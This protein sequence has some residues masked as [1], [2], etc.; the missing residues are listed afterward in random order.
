MNRKTG[1]SL[2]GIAKLLNGQVIG[3]ADIIISDLAKIE[4]ANKNSITFIANPKYKQFLASTK[5]GAVL[6]NKDLDTA[7]YSGKNFVVVEDPY[8]SFVKLFSLFYPQG[9]MLPQEISES[10]Y[11]HPSAKV[12]EGVHIAPHVYIGEDCVV[13]NNVYL[14]PGVVLLKNVTVGDDTILYPNVSVRENC[15]IGKRV[16]IHNGGVIGSDGFG[17]A[18]QGGEYHKIPQLGI[19][20]IEDD[21]ELG[22]NITID[23]ATLGETRIKSGTK[24]D[25]L[26]QVA[27]NVEI[28]N[29][30]V[31]AAQTGISGSTKIGSYVMMGGQVGV[32]GHSEVGDRVQVA[33]QSGIAKSVKD[34]EI[35]LGSPARPM[36]KAKRIEAVISSLPDMARKISALQKEVAELKKI[37]EN[38]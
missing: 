29:H 33:A 31:I 26:I 3:D 37:V 7:T 14:Y 17:F 23:R 34:G 19:V 18:F 28:G 21:V 38:K 30:T 32:V 4:E 10:A 16:I 8:Y 2:G 20:V 25:N 1:M 36:M 24:L 11:I 27:H 5:A 15:R 12:G 9:E 13:G 35:L 22:A 6:V